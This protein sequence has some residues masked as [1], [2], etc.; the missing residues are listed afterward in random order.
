MHR[1]AL[2]LAALA[3]ASIAALWPEESLAQALEQRGRSVA[4]RVCA[5]CHPVGSAAT[6]R[7]RQGPASFEAIANTPGMTA[8]A[9]SIWLE[10]PHRDMPHIL[11]ERDDRDAVVAYITSL[12]RTP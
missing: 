9:L 4:E 12:K 7:P 1:T 5:E 11:L 8:M 3:C 10:T 2:A 6:G